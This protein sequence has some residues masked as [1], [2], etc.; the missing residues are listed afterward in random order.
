MFIIILRKSNQDHVR[1][2]DLFTREFTWFEK[3]RIDKI[4]NCYLDGQ[5]Y[6]GL[7]TWS[8]IEMKEADTTVRD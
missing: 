1:Q 6:D 8:Y 7:G 5:A 3:K 2:P 4:Q